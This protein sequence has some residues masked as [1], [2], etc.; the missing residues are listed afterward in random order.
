MNTM[1]L[2]M[3]GALRDIDAAVM[4]NPKGYHRGRLVLVVAA[5]HA[6]LVWTQGAE[7]DIGLTLKWLRD[8]ASGTL[9]PVADAISDN[10]LEDTPD[11]VHDYFYVW[12]GLALPIDDFAS[13]EVRRFGSVE[14]RELHAKLLAECE[15]RVWASDTKPFAVEMY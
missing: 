11:A 4:L 14:E 15:R 5:D 12:K 6:F 8:N 7:E 1:K 13:A 3:P 2:Y 9:I 10:D